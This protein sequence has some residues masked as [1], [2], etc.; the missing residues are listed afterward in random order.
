MKAAR[1]AKFDQFKEPT[2][3]PCGSWMAN[4][5]ESDTVYR[6]ILCTLAE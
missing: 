6:T 4:E 3:G 1:E 2:E 5:A